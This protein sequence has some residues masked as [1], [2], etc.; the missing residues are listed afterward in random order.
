[1][2]DGH[3]DDETY[4]SSLMSMDKRTHYVWWDLLNPCGE[5]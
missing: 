3:L 4:L 2:I 5:Y 1:M